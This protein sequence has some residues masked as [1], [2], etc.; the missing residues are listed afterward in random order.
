MLYSSRPPRRLA[1]RAGKAVA[2]RLDELFSTG[3]A[4]FR[5]LAFAHAGST[6]GDTLVAIALANSLFFSVPSSEARGNVAL[7]LLLTVA[8]FALIGPVLGAVLDRRGA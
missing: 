4:G 3:G 5:I 8:P 6:A 1:R 2:R 7:Y